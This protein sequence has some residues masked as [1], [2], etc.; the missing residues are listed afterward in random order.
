MFYEMKDGKKKKKDGRME[1][2][3]GSYDGEKKVIAQK[4]SIR[5]ITQLVLVR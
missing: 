2:E 4:G 1:W 5:Q 3:Q